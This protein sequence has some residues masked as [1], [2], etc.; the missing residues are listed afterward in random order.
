MQN[1]STAP[2]PSTVIF[3]DRKLTMFKLKDLIKLVPVNL[4][5]PA[6]QQILSYSKD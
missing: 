3:L 6:L 4:N 2:K 1:K 5:N